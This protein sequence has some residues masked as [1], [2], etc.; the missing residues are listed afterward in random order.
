MPAG[1][2]GLRQVDRRQGDPAPVPDHRLDAELAAELGIDQLEMIERNRVR[3]GTRIEILRSLGE[4][5]A[6][7]AVTL[8][9]CGLG[10]MLER[11]KTAFAWNRPKE[12]ASS[13]FKDVWRLGRGAVIIQ[14]GSGLPGLD[15]ANAELSPVT[16]ILLYFASRAQNVDQ[17]ILP[18]LGRG[19]IVLSDRFTDSSLV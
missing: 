17:W 7:S 15:A 3:T 14:Q 9:E 8:G 12:R 4:G 13:G 18:A 10:E 19:E 2:K 5:R 6:G 16:E 1:T 11:G